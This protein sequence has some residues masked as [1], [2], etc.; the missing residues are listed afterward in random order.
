MASVSSVFADVEKNPKHNHQIEGGAMQITFY[1][2]ALDIY[3]FN[4]A[5]N[6]IYK[7][8]STVVYHTMLLTCTY[9]FLLHFVLKLISLCFILTYNGVCMRQTTVTRLDNI[10]W[11]VMTLR[12]RLF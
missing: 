3:P 8:T 12:A 2:L 7:R 4:P 9:H 5:G 11:L 1:K 6:L 10:R